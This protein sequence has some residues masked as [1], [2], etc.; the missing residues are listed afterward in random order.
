MTHRI[1][2]SAAEVAIEAHD[3]HMATCRARRRGLVCSTCIE[4][5]VLVASVVR[6]DEV[7]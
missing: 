7:A 6:S 3:I 2:P 4:L 1:V 5:V